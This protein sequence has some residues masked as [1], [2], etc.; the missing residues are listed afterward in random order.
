VDEDDLE[1]LDEDLEDLPNEMISKKRSQL[2][3]M[4]LIYELQKKYLI[5]AKR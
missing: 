2:L 4:N 5:L 1:D 3:L